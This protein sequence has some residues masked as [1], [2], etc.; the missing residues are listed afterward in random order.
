MKRLFV[1][2]LFF[3]V[4]AFLL[5]PDAA[6]S[7][8]RST[9]KKA[10]KKQSAS[11]AKEEDEIGAYRRKRV[12]VVQDRLYKKKGKGEFTVG[13]GII[14]DNSF[15]F[16]T[17]IDLKATYHIT[18]YLGVEGNFAYIIDSKKDLLTTIED[19]FNQTA[20]TDIL[21]KYYGGEFIFTPLYGKFAFLT[22]D[23]LHWDFFIAIGVGVFD[24]TQS[25]RF[26]GNFG[27]GMHVIFNKWLSGRFDFRNYTYR[28]VIGF[29]PPGGS[30]TT[31][32][33]VVNTQEFVFGV[34]TY[35]PNL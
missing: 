10:V 27:I 31:T 17:L 28:E 32:G 5:W 11:S 29:T 12:E 30:P 26:A 18:E 7:A 9:G 33:S 25:N 3:A 35:L 2:A 24:T 20:V 21:E 22:K 4:P 34:S 23:I 13:L 1:T 8:A 6:F 15:R 19:T 16:Y 14:P